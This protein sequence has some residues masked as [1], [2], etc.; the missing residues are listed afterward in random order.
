M[1]IKGNKRRLR[2]EH[3]DDVLEGFMQVLPTL[4]KD[5][6]EDLERMAVAGGIM[7]EIQRKVDEVRGDEVE[8]SDGDGVLSGEDSDSED[9][10]MDI[11]RH[12]DVVDNRIT[13]LSETEKERLRREVRELATGGDGGHWSET[14]KRA[15]ARIGEHVQHALV[16][17]T[18]LSR[19]DPQRLA[20]IITPPV[21]KA[22][23]APLAMEPHRHDRDKDHHHSRDNR[24]KGQKHG[25]DKDGAHGQIGVKP[26]SSGNV[27]SH[28]A[29]DGALP[30]STSIPKLAKRA[31]KRVVPELVCRKVTEG[32]AVDDA[33]KEGHGKADEPDGTACI[34]VPGLVHQVP[35]YFCSMVACQKV[36]RRLARKQQHGHAYFPA[37]PVPPE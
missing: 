15:E 24:G 36:A 26:K 10:D 19:Q 28:P 9:E 11:V 18:S 22:P 37:V 30:L 6:V 32:V 21:R 29:V 12:I 7:R 31:K 2:D 5:R 4:S 8:V 33:A 17:N 25:R 16:C 27:L 35:F 14:P 20:T 3:M 23:R 13:P 1:N 34:H